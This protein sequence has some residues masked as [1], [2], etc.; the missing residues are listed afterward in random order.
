MFSAAI[1][2]NHKLISLLTFASIWLSLYLLLCPEPL[3]LASKRWTLIPTGFL[4]AIIGNMSAI[5]GG[6]V[7]IPVMLFVYKLP[8]IMALKIA[9]ASQ[10][11]GMTTGA[12]NWRQSTPLCRRSFNSALP[13]LLIGSTISCL[14]IRP[15]PH[16]I[17]G[18]FGPVSVLLGILILLTAQMKPEQTKNEMDTKWKT[19]VFF[20]ALLGGFVSGC[21]AVGEGEVV[22]AFLML[23]VGLSSHISIAT[24]VALLAVTSIFLCAI[25][26]FFLGGIP[27]DYAWF[28]SL[29]CV[30]GA[31]TAP[32]LAR[33]YD[34]KTL[35]LIFA[36]IAILDGCLFIYQ[37]LKL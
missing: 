10:A 30:F 3:V 25:H 6:L 13:A 29:G 14:L 18:S 4:G 23:A 21:V 36:G 26:Q 24:G 37:S 16:L 19:P 12:V 15:N 9:L 28:T 32:V 20:V 5:G 8:P 27:W 7:F 22:A 17:K 31:T 11:I 33:K 35:R 34:G 1:T 2:K